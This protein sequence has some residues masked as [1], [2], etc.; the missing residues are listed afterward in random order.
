M[1]L[2]SEPVLPPSYY[3]VINGRLK[4]TTNE[5]EKPPPLFE[6]VW[7]ISLKKNIGNVFECNL[8]TWYTAAMKLFYKVSYYY[9]NI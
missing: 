6:D 5:E 2:L 3:D 4:L 9:F 1:A 7:I 8:N